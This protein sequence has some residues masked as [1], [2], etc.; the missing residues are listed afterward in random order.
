MIFVCPGPR[1]ASLLLLV[2]QY[3]LLGTMIRPNAGKL[4]AADYHGLRHTHGLCKLPG[5]SPCLLLES[6]FDGV[7]SRACQFERFSA[8]MMIQDPIGVPPTFNK[9]EGFSNDTC[10]LTLRMAAL[11]ERHHLCSWGE[12]VFHR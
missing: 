3:K 7:D 4:G 1:Q 5:G 8:P 10:G 6:L 2:S 12:I 11:L 9:G